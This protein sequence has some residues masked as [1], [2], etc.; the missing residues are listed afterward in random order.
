MCVIAVPN[1]NVCGGASRVG[2][3]HVINALFS[4]LTL[5]HDVDRGGLLNIAA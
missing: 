4:C 3:A 1:A 2:G 5:A